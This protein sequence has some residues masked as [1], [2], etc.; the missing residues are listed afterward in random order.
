MEQI[1][2]LINIFDFT[3]YKAFLL[4]K[5]LPRG[6]YSHGHKN[7]NNWAKRLGYKSPSSLSMILS[8]ERLPSEQMIKKISKDLK[9]TPRETRYFKLLVELE[10]TQ[11]QNKDSGKIQEEIKKLN[12]EKN[13]YQID[14]KNFTT[15]SEWY[16]L[17]IKQLISTP[18][19]IEDEQWIYKRLRKKVSIGQIRLALKDLEDLEIIKRDTTGR[20]QVIKPGL[21]TSNDVPSSAIRKHHSGMIELAKTAL[22]EQDVNERQINSTTLKVN[23]ADIP[24]AKKFIFDFIKEFA[25]RFNCDA[26]E[27]IYQLNVQLFEL[28]KDIRQ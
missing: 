1:D 10:K 14:L 7:L 2:H 9:L 4:K 19:F 27:N 17:A 15:I 13:S 28:T 3:D 21:I 26:S 20:F 24:E 12:T 23:S 11:K 18:N 8:G 22:I 6:H 5:G 25:A 16:Y